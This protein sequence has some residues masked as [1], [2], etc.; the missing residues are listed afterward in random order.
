MSEVYVPSTAEGAPR[1]YLLYDDR[2]LMSA[3]GKTSGWRCP[4]CGRRFVQRTREHSCEVRTVEMHLSRASAEIRSTF[5][6]LLTV[7]ERFG[8]HGVV[9]V[10]TMI[11]LRGTANFAGIVVRRDSLNV[12]FLSRR[13]YRHAR[14][15]KA[16][17]LGT[18]Y[19]H[20]IRLTSPAD[21]DAPIRGMAGRSLRAGSAR[22]PAVMS[23]ARRAS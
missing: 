4:Q 18:K 2:E 5:D 1:A 15:H 23:A 21:V 20:H 12:N 10:K 22:F 11:L 3:P 17:R 19:E 13:A 9:P 14:I 6:K 7:L 16:G 8:P